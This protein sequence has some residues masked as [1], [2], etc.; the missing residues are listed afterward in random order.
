[1]T[2]EP[3]SERSAERELRRLCRRHGVPYAIGA[4]L[5][6][7]VQRA[8]GAQAGLRRA[9]LDVVEAALA[10]DAE[11]VPPDE[12]ERRLL[13]LVASALHRWGEASSG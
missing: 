2:S 8:N 13:A 4:R 5:L 12:T 3:R 7:L 11:R 10:R 6:P 1:M 9:L